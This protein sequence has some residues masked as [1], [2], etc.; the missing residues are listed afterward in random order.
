M[1]EAET[2]VSELETAAARLRAGE[3]DSTEAAELVERC[4][5]LAARL[6]AALEGAARSS[7]EGEPPGQESL[8]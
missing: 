5:E 2:L 4:A 6:G 8:L 3:L 1:T 7:A